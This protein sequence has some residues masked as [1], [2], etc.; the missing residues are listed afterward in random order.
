LG[1]VHCRHRAFDRNRGG[2][3]N[4]PL[5]G[6]IHVVSFD[7]TVKNAILTCFGSYSLRPAMAFAPPLASET[8]DSGPDGPSSRSQRRTTSVSIGR[9]L[10]IKEQLRQYRL[11]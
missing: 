8:S 5:D 9:P 7:H 2:A 10:A 4:A 1:F 3:K 11:N 6:S